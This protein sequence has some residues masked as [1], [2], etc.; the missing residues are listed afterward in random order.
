MAIL[1]PL[2]VTITN[3]AKDHHEYITLP[4]K[5][6]DE[7]MGSHPVPF[8]SVIYIDSSDFREDEDP[9]F[10]R[11]TPGKTVGLLHV[12]FPITAT[13]VIKDS[14]GK[15]VEVQAV[16]ENSPDF[17]VKPKTY[18]QWI[19]ESAKDSSPVEIEIRNYSQLFKHS[20]PFDKKLV[21][22]GWLSDI[23]PNSLEIITTAIAEVGIRSC[24][25]ED[26]YQF[27]RIG[28]YCVDKDSDIPSGKFVLNRTVSLKEDSKKE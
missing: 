17:K 11:L 24:K 19:A 10:F 18:I 21:P 7:S 26:K 15:I 23:N 27:L 4:N 28:Y 3:L 16:Y 13:S 2:K 5:P 22:D 12:P 20:N 8:T 6:R 25:I 9:N 1:E 14:N